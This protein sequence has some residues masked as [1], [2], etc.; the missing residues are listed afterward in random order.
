MEKTFDSVNPTILLFWLWLFQA[1]LFN[2]ALLLIQKEGLG[3]IQKYSHLQ[4]NFQ[5]TSWRFSRRNLFSIDLRFSFLRSCKT[6]FKV[7]KFADDISYLVSDEDAETSRC[8]ARTHQ[9]GGTEKQLFL[10]LNQTE[11]K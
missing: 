2:G 11:S 1:S 7:Y 5:L 8:I 6:Y 4:R 10:D 3:T 9:V